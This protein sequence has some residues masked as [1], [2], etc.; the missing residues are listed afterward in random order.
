MTIHILTIICQNQNLFLNTLFIS[1]NC[2]RRLPL[3]HKCDSESMCFVEAPVCEGLSL[4]TSGAV[5][6][7]S[8]HIDVQNIYVFVFRG[9]IIYNVV[10]TYID[11][12]TCLEH[13]R[14]G[15][16]RNLTSIALMR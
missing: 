9:I 11:S 1:N 4:H 5:A 13:F 7:L 2:Q 10:G 16:L 3:S 15:T 6:R 14:N 12:K 8:K